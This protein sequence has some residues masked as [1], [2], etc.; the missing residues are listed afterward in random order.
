ME[1]P[2]CF[3]HFLTDAADSAVQSHAAPGPLATA[4]LADAADLLADAANLLA[5]AANI[6]AEAAKFLVHYLAE[7]VVELDYHTFQASEGLLAG[8]VVPLLDHRPTD[9]SIVRAAASLAHIRRV[10]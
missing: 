1:A 10:G 9:C 6:R 4:P 3:V 7:A 8:P 5:D 2:D